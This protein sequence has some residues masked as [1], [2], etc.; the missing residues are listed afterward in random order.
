MNLKITEL[1]T[2]LI[3][4]TMISIVTPIIHE[5]KNAGDN[6]DAQND[7]GQ[8]NDAVNNFTEKNDAEKKFDPKTFR[9]ILWLNLQ[10]I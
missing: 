8:N 10:Y 1:K 9:N 6:N 2:M 3:K 7:V 4:I 5:L